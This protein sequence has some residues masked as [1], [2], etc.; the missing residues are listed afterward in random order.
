M[1]HQPCLGGAFEGKSDPFALEFVTAKLADHRAS[2]QMLWTREGCSRT[3]AASDATAL[4]HR[5]GQGQLAG[6]TRRS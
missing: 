4:P 5:G 3:A 6:W 2:V 1:G